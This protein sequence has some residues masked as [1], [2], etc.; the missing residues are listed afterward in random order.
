MSVYLFVCAGV[1]SSIPETADDLSARTTLIISPLSVLSNWLV[2]TQQ[3]AHKKTHPVTELHL[4]TVLQIG[5]M[6]QLDKVK[7]PG[8]KNNKNCIAAQ[9]TSEQQ[10]KD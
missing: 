8:K 2:G 4:H 6:M 3:N 10:M 1:E 7:A 9:G 5:L